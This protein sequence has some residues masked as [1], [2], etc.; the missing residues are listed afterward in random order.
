M[1]SWFSDSPLQVRM[2]W[3][4]LWI[5]RLPF[6]MWRDVLVVRDSSIVVTR[7]F[8]EVMLL[9]RVFSCLLFIKC[10]RIGFESK[11]A[12]VRS[13]VASAV[14]LCGV[15]HDAFAANGQCDICTGQV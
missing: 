7:L 1:C 6:R 5:P 9:G 3:N 14:L 15:Y 10:C 12:T 4:I 8:G 11:D 2:H 13:A